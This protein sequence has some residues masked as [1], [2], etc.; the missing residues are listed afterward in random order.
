MR[1]FYCLQIL[2]PAEIEEWIDDKSGTA[3]CSYP[4]Y[5]NGTFN[6]TESVRLCDII[7]TTA[8]NYIGLLEA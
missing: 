7:R 1:L 3:I 8:Y 5:Q 4:S 2:D 6:L